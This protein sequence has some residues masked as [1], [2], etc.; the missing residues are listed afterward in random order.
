VS[1]DG[2]VR[3]TERPEPRRVVSEQAAATVVR[4]MTAIATDEGTAPLAAVPGYLVAGK[5]GTGKRAEGNKYAPGDVT[6][7]IGIVPADSPRYVISVFIHTQ[8]GLGGPIAGPMFSDL[9]GFTLR[10]YGVS[11]SGAA[12]PPITLYG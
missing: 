2:T 10:R 6:S 7:F 4:D 11:P 12:A 8:E 1:P 3:P 9:A 5:T